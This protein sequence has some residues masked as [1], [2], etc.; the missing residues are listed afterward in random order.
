[1]KNLMGNLVVILARARHG[2]NVGLVARAMKNTGLSH[3]VLVGCTDHHSKTAQTFGAPAREILDGAVVRPDLSAALKDSI[4]SVGFS[5]RE[6]RMR[7]NLLPFLDIVPSILD[8]AKSGRVCL[9]F[10]NER[11][12]LSTEEITR[13]DAASYLPSNPKFPSMNLSHAVMLAGYE[14][15]KASTGKE[16]LGG[17]S[18][19]KPEKYP[20]RRE[21]DRVFEEIEEVLRRLDYRDQPRLKLLSNILRNLRRMSKRAM[22]TVAEASM[23]RGILSRLKQR[24]PTRDVDKKRS[25]E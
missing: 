5:R 1:M 13:C 23:L 6:G 20:P 19:L 24:L 21:T 22:P 4:Y 7:L 3:L 18:H 16:S 14:L 11:T 25:S 2:G 17:V 8:K 9:V 10:G 15:L 12:G